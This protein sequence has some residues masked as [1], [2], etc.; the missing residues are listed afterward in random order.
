MLLEKLLAQDNG[1]T[2]ILY[3]I[4]PETHLYCKNSSRQRVRTA[5]QLL[6]QSTARAL[7][8]VFG[9]EMTTQ[10]EAIQIIN[11]WFD[12]MN[13]RKIYDKKI[14]SCGFGI[15]LE[16]QVKALEKMENLIKTMKIKNKSFMLPFQ[17]GIL[18]SI[19]AIQ[20]LYNVLHSSHGI[21]FLFSTHVNQDNLENLF[22]R[23]R[24]LN[25][26]YQHPT[27]VE[28]LRRLR[29]LM[30]GQNHDLAIH[31]P[32]VALPAEEGTEDTAEDVE[33]VSKIITS[34]IPHPILMEHEDLLSDTTVQEIE[35]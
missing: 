4:K 35:S 6:S 27:P 2:R 25:S 3:K 9:E 10:A 17:K 22:S 1:E 31:K 8:F 29:I 13:S 20:G 30:I 12:V 33:C 28:A 32:S 14:L 11:D 18:I 24:A 26:N 23:L 34:S 21:E 5:A 7:T 19:K 16:E 15:H